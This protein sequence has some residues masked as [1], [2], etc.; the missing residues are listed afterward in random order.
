MRLSFGQELKLVQQQKLAPRMIQSMEILQLPLM[1][2]EERIEQEIQE[3]PC[4]EKS[5][6]DPDLP[7]EDVEQ[8]N[9]DA[10]TA[11]EKELVVDGTKDNADED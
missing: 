10:P 2:L 5:E 6:N 1:A 8:E 11:E 4:L 7:D 3:N 9:P